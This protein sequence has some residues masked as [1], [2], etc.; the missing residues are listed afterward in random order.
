MAE[1][2]EA[3]DFSNYCFNK[4]T[5]NRRTKCKTIRGK[6]ILLQDIDYVI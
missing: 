1:K 4:N 3:S 5:I 2:H 6:W